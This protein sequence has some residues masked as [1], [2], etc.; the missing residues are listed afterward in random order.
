MRCR[1]ARFS[2]VHCV[3]AFLA[4]ASSGDAWSPISADQGS[5]ARTKSMWQDVKSSIIHSAFVASLLGGT[6]FLPLGPAIAVGDDPAADL[7]AGLSAATEY[8]PQI[9]YSGNRPNQGPSARGPQA[10]QV[11][12]QKGGESPILQ[13]LVYVDRSDSRP[14]FADTLVITAGSA[15]RSDEILAGAKIPVTMAR[16]P[17]QFSMYQ[18]NIARG[19]ED[20]WS[21][22]MDGDIIVTARVCPEASVLPCNDA[23]S[24]YKAKGISKNIRNLPGMDEGTTVRTAISLPLR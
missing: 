15:E 23:E 17:M 16:F 21:K 3:F 20:L 4:A 24:T 13:G 11:L 10:L 7:S 14:S 2:V 18:V 22:A 9:K 6:L 5:V 12:P 19:K 1:H 8:Q